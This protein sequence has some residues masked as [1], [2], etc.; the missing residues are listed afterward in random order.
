MVVIVP[1]LSHTPGRFLG[2]QLTIPQEVMT[3]QI[4]PKPMVTKNAPPI[5]VLL[6]L[7]S[8]GFLSTVQKTVPEGMPLLLTMES[9]MK[10]DNLSN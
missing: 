2:V 5:E 1:Q 3:A 7:Q 4:A 9:T 8:M 6:Q 10:I